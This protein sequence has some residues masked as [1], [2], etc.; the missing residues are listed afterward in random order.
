MRALRMRSA[1]LAAT[2]LTAALLVGCDR[3][4]AAPEGEGPASTLAPASAPAG[5]VLAGKPL[6]SH[7]KEELIIRD[8][9]GDRRDGFF[10]DVGCA[11]P[12]ESSNT[13]Y[14]EK[15]LGWSGI[16]VD[17][18]PDYGPGWQKHR[19]RSQFFA[20]LVS[21][22]S[23]AMESFYRADKAPDISSTRRDMKGP[24]G[25]QIPL[26]E[27]QVPTITLTKLLEQSRVSKV[28]FLS[29]D[30]E[31][32]EPPALAGFDID[33]FKPELAC[34]E[35]KPDT[36]EKIHA[37]FAAHGYAWLERYLPHDGVNHYFA[38]KGR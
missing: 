37:Y 10:L 22:H 14:L 7:N 20:F 3:P 34:I 5:S 9:F 19:P 6:Y 21:D 27:L 12:I 2:I 18:L 13:Y 26:T 17:A 24:A 1:R 25:R 4:A 30:I 23:D 38:P 33:R 11:T 28:D 8:F 36:R 16:A 15:H 31:G 29:M 32:S 35:I